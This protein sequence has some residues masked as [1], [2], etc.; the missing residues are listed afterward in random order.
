MD[1]YPPTRNRRTKI[2]KISITLSPPTGGSAVALQP[3]SLQDVELPDVVARCTEWNGSGFDGFRSVDCRDLRCLMVV[4]TRNLGKKLQTS[5][6]AKC[7]CL[8]PETMII[9][10]IQSCFLGVA[11]SENQ[12]KL[13]KTGNLNN[14]TSSIHESCRRKLG[15]FTSR[16]TEAPPPVV[17]TL[18]RTQTAPQLRCGGVEDFMAPVAFWNPCF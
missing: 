14:R 13:E 6:V 16:L 3:P 15:S 11:P 7:I 12:R 2:S 5:R 18:Q 10:L 8:H 17:C 9:T 1:N 4:G